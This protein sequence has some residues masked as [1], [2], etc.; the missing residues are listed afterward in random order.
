[1]PSDSVLASIV[2]AG[3]MSAVKFTAAGFSGSAV[4]FAEGLRSA[5]SCGN[6]A[7]MALG[8]RRGRKPPDE[9][10]P[11][12]YGKELYFWTLIVATFLFAV[13]GGGTVAKGVWR[14]LV[15]QD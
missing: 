8:Q 3:T 14:V 9:L 2:S 15:P 4:M 11:F 5:A 12:G 6:N 1:M 10:H 13:V 7:L